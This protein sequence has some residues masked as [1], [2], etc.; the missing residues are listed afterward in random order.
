MELVKFLSEDDLDLSNHL[1]NKT[2]KYTC[3]DSQNDIISLLAGQI[4]LKTLP[5]PNQLY[6][7]IADETLDLSKVEQV[8]VCL[9]YVKD[10][11]SIEE[12]FFGFFQLK[13]KPLKLFLI[14]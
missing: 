2:A 1:K 13:F 12:R 9:R 6:S 8:C 7:I 3:H 4:R 5:K 14:F 10:D 11:M